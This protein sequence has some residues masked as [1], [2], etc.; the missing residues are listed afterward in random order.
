[1]LDTVRTALDTQLNEPSESNLAKFMQEVTDGL[2][3]FI[4]TN[5]FHD[6]TLANT[7]N[8]YANAMQQAWAASMP[9]TADE[10]EGEGTSEDED[11][12]EVHTPKPKA[13]SRRKAK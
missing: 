8:E 6:G 13:S 5:H 2:K 12:K 4:N 7:L 10:S 1:M 3:H 9:D 11:V